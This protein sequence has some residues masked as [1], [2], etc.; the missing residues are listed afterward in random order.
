MR[1]LIP[2][3]IVSTVAHAGSMSMGTDMRDAGMRAAAPSASNVVITALPYARTTTCT[4][5]ITLTGSG[6][7]AGAVTWAASPSGDSGA[8]TGT[9]SWSCAVSV[10]PN[11]AGEG[12]ETIT[13]TQ[14]ST[15]SAAV[16]V[17]FYVAGSHSCFLA[18]NVDGTN[19]SSLVNGNPVATWENLGSSALD[20]TQATGGAQPTFTTNCMGSTPCLRFDGG[21][22]LQAGAAADWA[23]LNSGVDASLSLTARTTSSNPDALF[24]V[25]STA[26]Q[27]A[28]TGSRGITLYYDDRSGSSR[29]D[30]VGW[31]TSKGSAPLS[32][33]VTSA[34]GDFTA[35]TWHTWT[36]IVDDD[37]GAGNDGFQFVDG[38][39]VGAAVATT[40]SAL[41]PAA[42]LTLGDEG[43]TRTFAFIGDMGDVLIY[44]TAL[45]PTERGINNAV[46]AWSSGGALVAATSTWLFVGDSLTAGSGGVTTWP[47][48]LAA[49]APAGVRLT[50][51]AVSSTTAAQILAQWRAAGVPSRVF[52]L[53]GINDIAVGT[54]G[55][56]A[57]ASLASIYSE[58][59]ALGVD[60]VAMATLPFGNA[61]SWTAPRQTQLLALNT[62]VLADVNVD[63]D[64][65]F[66]TLMG[67]A[68]V[69]EDLATLYDNGDGVHPSEAGTTFMADTVAATLGL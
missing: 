17:G 51:R 38:A 7:G 58:A 23:F 35:A 48:K 67:Q 43:T 14:A 5:S 56:T 34:N 47:A 52:V 63:V 54:S 16:D 39:A 41:A 21:D 18:Q 45:T 2:L 61:A 59:S 57:Y 22:K 65:D 69:P 9:T 62:S 30:L 1:W 19:N 49:F 26:V 11:A 15:G 66:Y 27:G 29:N 28:S 4:G 13:V 8:C 24:Y 46:A 53:G 37:A 3:L 44:S 32:V 42:P 68:G 50:N 25:A 31:A 33:S 12:V 6:V 36:A 60:V 64:V 55:A 40:Y 10:A 20:V